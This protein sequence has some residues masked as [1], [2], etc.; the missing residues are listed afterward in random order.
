MTVSIPS[1]T[2]PEKLMTEYGVYILYLMPI[3]DQIDAI[4]SSMHFERFF[5]PEGYEGT[6]A[7]ASTHL[8]EKIQSIKME[9]TSVDNK[10]IKT[11]EDRKDDFLLANQVLYKFNKVFDVRKYAAATRGNRADKKVFYIICGW[12]TERMPQSFQR[13]WRMNL[14][15]SVFQKRICQ[16]FSALRLLS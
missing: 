4:Y 15:L 8:E 5:L 13:N 2:R 16:R 11:L 12:L 14:K 6:P 1:S 10:I 3:S 9:I 7:A